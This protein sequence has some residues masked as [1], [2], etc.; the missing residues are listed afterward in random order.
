M[1]I[2]RRFIFQFMGVVAI[3]LSVVACK[4]QRAL[5]DDELALV[6]RDAFLSNAYSTTKQ[7]NLDSLRLYEPIFK[8]YGYTT[9][10]V[11][12]TIGNF[13]NRKSARLSDVVEN[14][15]DMLE[16]V[17]EQLDYEVAILDTID[18]ISV[19]HTTKTV[20]EKP[21]IEMRTLRDTSKFIIKIKDLAE[22]DYNVEFKYLVDTLDKTK[23]NYLSRNWIEEPSDDP[24]K[25]N[26]RIR[27]RNA[28]LG[29]DNVTK[30][31]STFSIT[32]TAQIAVLSLAIPSKVAGKPHLTI[33]NLVVRNKPSYSQ[34]RDSLFHELCKITIFDDELLFKK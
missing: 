9:A 32:D 7:L 16:E 26:K 21:L 27:V 19:R 5:S 17:G 1:K 30:F 25:A 23:G 3:L 10:D 18:Q 15:I 20:Y 24:K 22:G 2:D 29:R 31:N 8:K 11:Q 14:A 33:K 4:K 12:Y 28:V 13:A 6:F 34:A